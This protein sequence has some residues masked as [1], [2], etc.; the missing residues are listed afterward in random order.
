MV[1]RVHRKSPGYETGGRISFLWSIQQ[2]L[3]SLMWTERSERFHELS[4]SP[5]GWRCV[6]VLDSGRLH[7]GLDQQA[8]PSTTTLQLC[9]RY[10]APFAGDDGVVQL[11]RLSSRRSPAC[12]QSEA[13]RHLKHRAKGQGSVEMSG[14]RFTKKKKKKKR[15]PSPEEEDSLS[16]REEESAWSLDSPSIRG[17]D[18]SEEGTDES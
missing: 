4:S 10:C 13:P 11:C 6:Q 7:T 18:S 2:L 1:N 8:A 9:V 5:I 15:L 14:Q 17:I 12:Q 3:Q 16:A